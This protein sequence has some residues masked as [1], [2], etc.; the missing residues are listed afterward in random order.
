[1]SDERREELKRISDLLNLIE[2]VLRY[3]VLTNVDS[4][5]SDTIEG[6][7]KVKAQVSRIRNES[8]ESEVLEILEL[9]HNLSRIIELGD[10]M[11][12]K[13]VRTQV[14]SLSGIRRFNLR[15]FL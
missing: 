14:R 13:P 7:E 12:K 5:V 6:L 15:K 9:L 2:N 3:Q 4:I 11:I 1:M 8:N 10:T